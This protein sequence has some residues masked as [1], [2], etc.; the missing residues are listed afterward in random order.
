MTDTKQH[1]PLFPSPAGCQGCVYLTHHFD[2]PECIHP[3]AGVE[4]ARWT[5]PALASAEDGHCGPSFKHHATTWHDEPKWPANWT[6]WPK[7]KT[8]E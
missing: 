2:M 7:A 3:E 6:T 8:D 4:G 5:R 1:L